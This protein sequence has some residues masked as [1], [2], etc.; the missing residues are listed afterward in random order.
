MFCLD[1]AGLSK[2]AI[3]REDGVKGEGNY[4]AARF[5]LELVVKAQRGVLSNSAS[6]RLS[7]PNFAQSKL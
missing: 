1:K 4:Q 7:R 5:G 2:S 3:V 6:Q